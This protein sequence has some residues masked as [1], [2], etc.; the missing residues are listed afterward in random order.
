[1]QKAQISWL[2]DGKRLHLHHG[3][4]DMIV[5]VTG[6]DRR[7]ALCRAADRFENLLDE[8]VMELPRLRS[9]FGSELNGETA[10][11]MS[12]AVACF[13]TEF[14]TPMA[15]V[16]GAGAET[17]LNAI[18]D[19]PGVHKAYVNNGGDV[20][21]ALSPGECMTAVVAADPPAQVRIGYNTPVRGIASSGWRGRSHSLGIAD[22]VT[23]LAK[24]AAIA[25]A[26]ATLIA[27][28]IDL[29]GHAAIDRRPASEQSPDSDLGDRLV[30]VGVGSLTSQDISVALENGA[31][32]A[33]DFMVRGLISGA[34]LTLKNTFHH[35]GEIPLFHQ[36]ELQYA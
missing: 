17:V 5:D 8:L 30:T 3:P 36:K 29:P 18:C 23:V 25:D 34:A 2:P 32:Q 16:A 6:P 26:A 24:S 28:A 1:M 21:F 35:V 7:A 15:A 20:A 9:A 13:P 22:N 31:S 33:Q 14:I 10:K 19:G 11:R 12:D 27:N 4:I